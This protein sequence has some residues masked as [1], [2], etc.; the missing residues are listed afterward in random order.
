MDKM[1]RCLSSPGC[2]VF[3]WRSASLLISSGVC[4]LARALGSRPAPSAGALS[5]TNH[6]PDFTKF[7][8]V[9]FPCFPRETLSPRPRLFMRGF[10]LL[11]SRSSLAFPF[12]KDRRSPLPVRRF[13]I[14]LSCFSASLT[15]PALPP[16]ALRPSL[17]LYGF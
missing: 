11:M 5:K 13:F 15:F 7:V 12:H 16:G 2:S 1:S 17:L 14:S 10:L 4:T 3:K 9:P 8:T 6:Q